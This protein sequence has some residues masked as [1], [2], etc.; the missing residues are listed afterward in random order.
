M[1]LP[2]V[3]ELPN[4]SLPLSVDVIVE[5]RKLENHRWCDA[6]WSV[7]GVLKGQTVEKPIVDRIIGGSSGNEQY[8]WQGFT[9]QLFADDAE[10][11]YNNLLG[12]QPGLFVICRPLEDTPVLEPLVVTASYD[13]AASYME[14]EEQVHRVAIDPEI[15]QQIESFVVHYYFPSEK[16]KRKR[17][18]WHDSGQRRDHQ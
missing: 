6:S 18:R 2:R 17:K 10:S 13:E 9:L 11:Y 4:R 14:V 3:E 8:R 7:V 1:K 16:K 12:Q 15:Y 5:K